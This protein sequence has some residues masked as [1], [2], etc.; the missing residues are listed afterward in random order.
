M[1]FNQKFI[2]NAFSRIAPIISFVS[3]TLVYMVNDCFFSRSSQS[4]NRRII[5]EKKSHPGGGLEIK[6]WAISPCDTIFSKNMTQKHQQLGR[7][8]FTSLGKNSTGIPLTYFSRKEKR[9]RTTKVI[10][11]EYLKSTIN[12]SCA[13]WWSVEFQKEKFPLNILLRILELEKKLASPF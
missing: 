9:P 13:G 2:S 11:A 4:Q 1:E 5:A 7:H 3:S 12:N 6:F 10:K 8:C